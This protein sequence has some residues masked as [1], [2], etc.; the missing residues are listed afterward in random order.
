M[1]TAEQNYR[2]WLDHVG[3]EATRAQLGNMTAEEIADAFY[4]DLEFGTGGMRG[5]MGIGT[6]CLND[7]T[8]AGATQGLSDYMKAYGM[9]SALVTYDSRL[10]S[11][12]FSRKAAAVLATNGIT[13]YITDDCMPTP[14]LSYAIRKMGVHIG[15]NIT[16]SHN[17]KEYNGYKVYDATGCQV[18]DEAAK[19]ITSFIEKIDPFTVGCGDYDDLAVRGLIRSVEEQVIASYMD[20]VLGESLGSAEGLHVVYTPLNGAGYAVVPEVLRRIGVGQLQIVPEQSMP[21]GHFTTCPFPNPEKVPALQLAVALAGRQNADIVVANDPDCDRL[22]VAVRTPDGY[23]VLTGNEVAVLL[24]DYILSTLSA[25][26]AL[27]GDPTLITTI[28]STP[29]VKVLAADYHAKVIEVLTGFKYIGNVLN[30]LQKRG[31]ESKF[32]FGFEESCGYL[33]GTYARDKDGVIAAMLVCEMAAHDKRQGIT[34]Y[35]RLQRLYEQYGYYEQRLI[36]YRF[37]GADGAERKAQLLHEMR[38]TPFST[39]AGSRV[40]SV[41]DLLQATELPPADVLIFTSE[42]GSKLVVRPSGTEPLI[43]CYLMVHGTPADNARCLD[44]IQAQLD[45][46]LQ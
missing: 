6:N 22:G 9:T 8:V 43:K 1:N 13:V 7:Y 34:L 4:K 24:A 42:D 28:V 11:R 19:E 17:P 33:K 30:A 37:D 16:A 44:A 21:D 12:D 36:S 46:T 5:K 18:L 39:L 27:P 25:R 14:F 32:V 20:A 29:M 40:V 23:S 10:H 45:K 35:E 38:T 41:S 2:Y 26:H 15:I 3:D 31:E